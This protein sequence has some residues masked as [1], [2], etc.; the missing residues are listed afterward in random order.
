MPRHELLI[1]RESAAALLIDVQEKLL[2]TLDRNEDALRRAVRL[3]RALRLLDIPILVTQQNT[4][5]FGP[6]VAPL[7]EALGAFTPLEKMNFSCL[8]VEAARTRLTQLGRRQLVVYGI[9]THICV[10]QSALDAVAAGFEV[11]VPFDACAA[12][13]AETHRIGVE[14]MKA[15]G[16]TPA[17]TESVIYDLLEKAGTEEFRKLLPLLKD[18]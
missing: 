3:T 9:E 5:V 17:S 14:K 15:G 12:H 16:V 6:T 8:A 10:C 2:P 11:H 13:G 1:S 7:H 18:R 4:R